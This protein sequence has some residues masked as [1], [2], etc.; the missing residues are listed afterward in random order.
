[1]TSQHKVEVIHYIKGD[2]VSR[3]QNLVAWQENAWWMAGWDIIK[4]WAG[5]F[6][7]LFEE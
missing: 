5:Y 4:F 2:I 1:M 7:V 6:N 3:E